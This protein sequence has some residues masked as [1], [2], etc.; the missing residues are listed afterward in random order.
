MGRT[1]CPHKVRW[2]VTPENE[3]ILYKK[4]QPPPGDTHTAMHRLCLLIFI[5]LLLSVFFYLL[6]TN[7]NE[8]IMRYKSH[9]RYGEWLKRFAPPEPTVAPPMHVFIHICN[10][11]LW[12]L[13]LSEIMDAMQQSGLYD[14]CAGLYYGCSCL[15]CEHAVTQRM[16]GVY[17][18]AVPLS[19]VPAPNHTHENWTI[20]AVIQFAGAHPGSHILYL[21]TKGVTNVSPSQRYWRQWMTNYTVCLWRVCVRFLSAGYHKQTGANIPETLTPV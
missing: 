1:V 7:V 2:V 8:H 3:I 12:E 15:D 4:Q 20:N 10:I 19:T 21:H 6:G 16:T 17:A 13:V 9:I 5:V 11:G 14:A 18:K